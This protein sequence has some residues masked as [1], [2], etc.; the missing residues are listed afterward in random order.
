MNVVRGGGVA[1]KFLA[2]KRELRQGRRGGE[3][4]RALPIF[5]PPVWT[6]TPTPTRASRPSPSQQSPLSRRLPPLL[7]HPRC[8]CAEP[9][10]HYHGPVRR[11]P[12]R[13]SL[14]GIDRVRGSSSP[15]NVVHGR[16]GT[17]AFS[18]HKGMFLWLIPPT[19]CFGAGSGSLGARYEVRGPR[20]VFLDWETLGC[21]G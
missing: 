12:P 9:E 14:L 8:R 6:G 19:L 7:H 16:V 13:L 18:D 3:R 17:A 2:G 10:L 21:S 20:R 15:G 5:A 4:A 1:D 11:Q